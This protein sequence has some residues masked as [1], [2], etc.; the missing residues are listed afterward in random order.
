[1]LSIKGTDTLKQTITCTFV[2]FPL[3]CHG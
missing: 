3:K 2:P 1:M